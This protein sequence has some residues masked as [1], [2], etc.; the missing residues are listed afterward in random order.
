M[1]RAAA[2]QDRPATQQGGA[3]HAARLDLGLV[4]REL[5]VDDDHAVGTLAARLHVRAH[6]ARLL[7]DRREARERRGAG[8]RGVKLERPRHHV[9]AGAIVERPAGDD[10]AGEL[11][12]V[13][14]ED[15]GVADGDARQ[16]RLAVGLADVDPVIAQVGGLAALGFGDQVRRPLAD[17]PV[18]RALATLDDDRPAGQQQVIDAAELVEVDEPVLIDPGHLQA[19]LVGM[20]GDHERGGAARRVAS[21]LPST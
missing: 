15:D 4:G 3:A 7:L 10:A 17:H 8:R 9:E 14:R 13:R 21:T 11:D 6:V 2:T 1:P 18:D 16:R 5:G 19:D 12:E 20:G